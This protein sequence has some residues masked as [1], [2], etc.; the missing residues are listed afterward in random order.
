MV[1]GFLTMANPTKTSHQP[2]PARPPIIFD[3]MPLLYEDDE[4]GDMGESNLHEI[5]SLILRAGLEAHLAGKTQ[6][7]VFSNLN[8]YYHPVDPKPYVSP[9]AMVVI[10]FAPLPDSLSS[11]RVNLQGPAPVLTAEILSERSSQQRDLKEKLTI[12]AQLQ[13]AEYILIDVSGVFLSQRLL[14]NR[15]DPNGA[16][17]P[18]KDSDG[19]VTSHLGFRLMIEADGGLRVIDAASGKRYVRPLEAELEAERRREAEKRIRELEAE[20]SQ[21]R[22]QPREKM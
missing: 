22:Q 21:L 15:L 19:G 8:L 4:E 14:L 17:K 2:V 5:T 13:V 12:Y 20:L 18:E 3:K 1:K 10:P 9:D 11:Y 6:Y 7:R 16:W